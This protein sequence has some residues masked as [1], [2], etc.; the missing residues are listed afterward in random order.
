MCFIWLKQ[1]IIYLF[2]KQTEMSE[3]YFVTLFKMG[4]ISDPDPRFI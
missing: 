4:G 2:I 3:L 1:T